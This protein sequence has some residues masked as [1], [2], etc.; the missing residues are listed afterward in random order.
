MVG[1]VNAQ[2]I[3]SEN[4]TFWKDKGCPLQQEIIFAS[5]GTKRPEDEPWKYVAA[6][7]GSDIQT[8]PPQ[9]NQAAAESGEQFSRRVDQ[10]PSPQILD[11][12][13]SQVDFQHM[14][15]TLMSEGIAKFADPQ[16]QLLALLGSRRAEMARA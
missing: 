11:E 14:Y 9:T 12:I 5:T 2:R 10:L 4:D 3:W 7:A 15:E 13:D 16:K 6:L 1:I 8:N